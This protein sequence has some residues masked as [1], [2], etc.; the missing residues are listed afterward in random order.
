MSGILSVFV[1]SSGGTLVINGAASRGNDDYYYGYN[2]GNFIDRTFGSIQSGV[3][4]GATI[5]G[6]YSES[7]V[8]GKADEYTVV[9]SGSQPAGFVTGLIVNGTAVV[10]D[11]DGWKRNESGGQ[12]RFFAETATTADTLFGTTVGAFIPVTIS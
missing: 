6:V 12:T 3:Y 9:F 1:G 5:I 10:P 8:V 4:K 7:K 11:A 2:A